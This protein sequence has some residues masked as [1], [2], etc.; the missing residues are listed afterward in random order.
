MKSLD[1]PLE[2]SARKDM[3]PKYSFLLL[4]TFEGAVNMQ[5]WSVLKNIIQVVMRLGTNFRKQVQHPV[6]YAPW[7][8]SPTL[9][10]QM[11]APSLTRLAC[12]SCR[13]IS[14]HIDTGTPP[15]SN[16]HSRNHKRTRLA[17][18]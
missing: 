6:H 1:N 5:E 3:T 18:D 8:A 15:R 12:K 9:F 16:H 17:L 2:D 10:S 4:L 13:Y 7:N 14:I 11:K